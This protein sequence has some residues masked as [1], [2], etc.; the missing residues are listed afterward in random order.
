MMICIPINSIQNIAAQSKCKILIA[1]LLLEIS[2]SGQQG[3]QAGGKLNEWRFYAAI[4]IEEIFSSGAGRCS[5]LAGDSN[6][7]SEHL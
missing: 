5:E 3:R 1:E 7:R 4:G 6:K 2:G